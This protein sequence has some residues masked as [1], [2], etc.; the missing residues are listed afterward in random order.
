M[1]PR[2]SRVLIKSWGSQVQLGKCPGSIL[3]QPS[4][5]KDRVNK[6]CTNIW[7]QKDRWYLLLQHGGGTD[8]MDTQL[9][10]QGSSLECYSYH[11]DSSSVWIGHF[12]GK[13]LLY[14]IV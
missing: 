11:G 14:H 7:V 4:E 10:G 8:S 5:N 6:F 2:L 13:T 12:F 9:L 3:P 1:T